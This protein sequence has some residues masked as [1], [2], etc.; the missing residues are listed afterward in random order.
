MGVDRQG[1]LEGLERL[2]LPAEPEP[3]Q[4][5]ADERREM[6]RLQ[7]QRAAEMP[8][9]GRKIAHLFAGKSRNLE[10]AAMHIITDD[11]LRDFFN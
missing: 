2:A 11:G 4:A 5:E 6:A 9:R 3:D 7:G 8:R 1:L 10:E